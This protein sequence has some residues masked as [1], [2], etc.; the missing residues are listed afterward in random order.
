MHRKKSLDFNMLNNQASPPVLELSD[1]EA[2][3]SLNLDSGRF[4]P[5]EWIGQGRLY[6]NVPSYVHQQLLCRLQNSM[7]DIQDLLPDETTTIFNI[8]ELDFPPIHALDYSPPNTYFLDQDT[9]ISFRALFNI[10]IPPL[11]LVKNLRDHAGQAMLDGK[12]SI[13]HPTQK[14]SCYL[15]FGAISFWISLHEA[16]EAKKSWLRALGWIKKAKISAELLHRLNFVIK[17]LP[18]KGSLSSLGS[19]VNI[20][21]MTSFLSHEMLTES[22]VDT[23]LALLEIRL[24]KSDHPNRE[25]I[26]IAK[27]EFGQSLTSIH[28]YPE[29]YP[30]AAPSNVVEKAENL[31]NAQT[32]SCIWSVAHSHPLHFGTL[33]LEKST[34][35]ALINVNWG[36]SIQRPQPKTM[37]VGLQTWISEHFTSFQPSFSEDLKCA[38]Q[39]DNFS[40][41]I[42]AINTIKHG[43]F[44]DALWC[45]KNGDDYRVG[46]FVAI[47]EYHL[48]SLHTCRFSNALSLRLSTSD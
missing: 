44:G 19:F 45:S 6:K 21:E 2:E 29:R 31:R 10:P 3:N 9:N 4:R 28:L 5:T 40:C 38:Q 36:D 14:S 48:V 33:F 27:T 12:K 39:N 26:T 23:M 42:I 34:D 30:Q 47:M 22:H 17:C 32:G 25:N 1:S 13:Q 46:E 35:K 18:W 20:T 11:Y 8:T 16:I 15:P 7:H 43:I 41:S 24:F 37:I